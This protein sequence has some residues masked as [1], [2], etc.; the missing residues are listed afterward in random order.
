VVRS[1]PSDGF[2]TDDVCGRSVNWPESE[3]QLQI[4]NPQRRSPP[5]SIGINNP[6]PAS[7]GSVEYV[8]ISSTSTSIAWRMTTLTSP[9]TGSA[10]HSHLKNY[11]SAGYSEGDHLCSPEIP[12]HRLAMS[13]SPPVYMLGAAL[14]QGSRR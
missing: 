9:A 7:A 5:A 6:T 8:E 3:I 11:L 10:L 2:V 13:Y 12:P 1:R 4:Y 14:A